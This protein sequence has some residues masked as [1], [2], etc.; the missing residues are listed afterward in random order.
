[1]HFASSQ[2]RNIAFFVM[3][4]IFALFVG[5]FSM[6]GRLNWFPIS[7]PVVLAIAFVLLGLVVLV[8]TVRL[9]EARTKRAFFL[10]AGASAAAMPICALLHN[11]VY[12]LFLWW[13]GEGFWERHGADEPVFF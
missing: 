4:L 12:G 2:I 7:L 5:L 3:V 13:F 6:V 11:V 10:L 9:N 8:L 1:M